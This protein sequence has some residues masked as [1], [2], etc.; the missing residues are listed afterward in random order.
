ME[1]LKHILYI[2]VIGVTLC[3]WILIRLIRG[4]RP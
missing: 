2:G 1:I 4:F 3:L